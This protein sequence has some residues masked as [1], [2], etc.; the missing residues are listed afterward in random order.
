LSV[1]HISDT[2]TIGSQADAFVT[3]AILQEIF[4][5]F[6]AAAVSIVKQAFF[7]KQVC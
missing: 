6:G 4:S 1:S 5:P 2:T 3:D 7:C